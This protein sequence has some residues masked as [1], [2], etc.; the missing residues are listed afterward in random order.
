MKRIF[1]YLFLIF[2]T[3]QT[4]SQANDIR[5]FQIEGM[6][7]GD[8]LLDY[9]SK[10][11]IEKSKQ[12][13]QY[14]G[15]SEYYIVTLGDTELGGLITLE[16]YERLNVSIN[17]DFIIH[18]IQAGFYFEDNFKDCKKMQKKIDKEL[19]ILFTDLRKDQ[20]QKKHAYDKTGKSISHMIVYYFENEDSIIL[21]C[22]DWSTDIKMHDN[23]S[24]SASTEIFETWLK[25][26]GY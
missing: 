17:K 26:E 23:L 14:P 11:D 19:S 15:S 9:F 4:P 2:F 22:V 12:E 16:T 8:S 20:Y 5:D 24:I 25:T 6:S 1:I 18:N 21:N 3:P 7:M 13:T 10:K